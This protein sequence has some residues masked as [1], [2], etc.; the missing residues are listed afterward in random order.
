MDGELAAAQRTVASLV[1]G[2]VELAAA[3]GSLH[4]CVAQQEAISAVVAA[5]VRNGL[6]IRAVIARQPTIQDLYFDT[7]T[8]GAHS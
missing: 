2:P 1:G 6:G 7:I 4:F 5:L 3:D 8:D